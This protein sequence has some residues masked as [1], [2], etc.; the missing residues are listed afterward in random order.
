MPIYEVSGRTTL[1][2]A[3]VAAPLCALRAV[4][5]ALRIWEIHVFYNT[6][7]TTAGGLGLAYST[8]LGTGTLTSV[9]P[10]A[11]SKLTGTSAPTAL[12]VTAWATLAP[13]NGGIGTVFRRMTAAAAA[14]APVIWTFDRE[15]L[16]VVGSAG[17]TSELCIVNTQALAPGTLDV[18]FVLEE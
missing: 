12:L 10:V 9:T 16:S 5:G 14:P 13:T 1:V 8:A 15:P 4:T 2:T 7:P 6:A 3:T 17:A 18:T 11:R